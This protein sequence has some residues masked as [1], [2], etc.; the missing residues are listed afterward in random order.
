ML[1][2]W[3]VFNMWRSGVGKVPHKIQQQPAL[4][5]SST[6]QSWLLCPSVIFQIGMDRNGEERGWKG[7]RMKREGNEDDCTGC[8]EDERLIKV[9]LQFGCNVLSLVTVAYKIGNNLKWSLKI[10]MFKVAWCMIKISSWNWSCLDPGSEQLGNIA[11]VKI[12]DCT[13]TLLSLPLLCTMP[14]LLSIHYASLP[15]SL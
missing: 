7:K 4:F 1:W 9:C 10:K 3:G 8:G 15:L 2:R 14:S 11:Q 6:T 5:S 13:C 12:A